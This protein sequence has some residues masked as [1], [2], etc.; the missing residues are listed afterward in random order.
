MTS[1]GQSRANYGRRF[2]WFAMAITVGIGV[3]SAGWFY[4][5]RYLEDEVR[6]R[7]AGMNGGGRRANCEEPQARGYPFRIGLFCRSVLYE[8][9]RRGLSVQARELRTAAQIYQPWRIIGEL[10]GPARLEAPGVNALALDWANLRASARLARPLPQ[11][12]SVEAQDLNI[13][14][15]EQTDTLPPLA[16][17]DSVEAHM[18][19]AGDDIDLAV[20]FDGLKP[21]ASLT[22]GISLPPLSGVADLSLAGAALPGGLADGLE[23]SLHG[24]SGTIRSVTVSVEGGAGVTVSGPVSVDEAGLIDAEL[25]ISVREPLVLARIL[26][27]LA[28]HARREIE[29]SFSAIAAMGGSAGM[30]LRIVKSEASL[31]FITLGTIPPL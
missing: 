10:D 23:G 4:A 27:D 13:R 5:A 11:R 6:G 28:P 15:D 30:P 24:R 22:N 8:D 29:L 17:F 12:I 7:V 19:P 9:A 18:R 3:Y 1:S 21:D 20:R 16:R 26:G 14:R 25:R 31:G 2:F